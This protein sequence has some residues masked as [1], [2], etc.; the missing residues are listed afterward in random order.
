MEPS[1][2]R[3]STVGELLTCGGRVSTGT[4]SWSR[5]SSFTELADGPFAPELRVSRRWSRTAPAPLVIPSS[6][7][8]SVGSTSPPA[9]GNSNRGRSSSMGGMTSPRGMSSGLMRRHS[10]LSSFSTQGASKGWNRL[11]SVVS[12]APKR[13]EHRR[14]AEEAIARL[15]S[16]SQVRTA[17]GMHFIPRE[18]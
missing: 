9:A 12:P 16:N 6:G 4:P 10:L 15:T 13:A 11:R 1:L 17:D 2:L 14:D 18:R 5:R 3:G 7:S 8:F